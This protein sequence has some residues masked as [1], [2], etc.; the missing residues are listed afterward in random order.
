MEDLCTTGIYLQEGLLHSEEAENKS[1][2]NTRLSQRAARHSLARQLYSPDCPE[3]WLPPP[4]S[5]Q[6]PL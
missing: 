5:Q 3:V 4:E 6:T 1:P 2:G